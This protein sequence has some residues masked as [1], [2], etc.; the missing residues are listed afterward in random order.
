[1]TRE[2]S[3]DTPQRR[4]R[5]AQP[6]KTL[7]TVAMGGHE[8]QRKFLFKQ[9]LVFTAFGALGIGAMW[10]TAFLRPPLPPWAS[11]L[12]LAAGLL[13]WWLSGT[14]R[15]R[16]PGAQVMLSL[17]AFLWTGAA[18]GHALASSYFPWERLLDLSALVGGL[19]IGCTLNTL[20]FRQPPTPARQFL[21]IGPWL[22]LSAL[23][24]Y[25][26]PDSEWLLLCGGAL[27]LL[28]IFL[29]LRAEAATL[30]VYQ[31]KEIWAAAADLVPLNLWITWSRLQGDR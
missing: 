15:L 1:M 6:V 8:V 13:S 7:F 23:A 26:F 16:R 28:L 30:Q 20:F 14:Q 3:A 2:P 4:L 24:I 25:F 31:V 12:G 27:G 19:L 10:L 11:W 22:L 29:A 18:A 17:L 9:R 21:L 5:S